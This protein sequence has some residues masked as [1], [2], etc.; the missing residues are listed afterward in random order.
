MP[1]DRTDLEARIAAATPDDTVR[2]LVFNGAFSVLREFGD[3]DAARECDPLGTGSRTDFFSY[4]VADYLN[5]AWAA[6]DRLEGVLRGTDAVFYQIGHRAL[7]NVFSSMLGRTLL[8]IA[9][10]DMQRLLSQAPSGYRATVSYGERAVDWPAK[11]HCHMVFKHDFLVPPFH[12]GVVSAAIEMM[13]GRNVQA[14]GRQT[15]FLEAEY[16]FKWE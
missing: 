9:A 12:C 6:A 5:L 3:E 2:G 11:N 14:A 16:D 8:T 4:P 1:A 15:G 10:G 7:T 13:G